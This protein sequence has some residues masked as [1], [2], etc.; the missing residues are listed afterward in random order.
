MATL[1]QARGIGAVGSLLILVG[2]VPN[3]GVLSI[4]GLILVLI[5]VKFIGEIV[6]DRDIYS[7][8]TIAVSLALIGAVVGILLVFSAFSSFIGSISTPSASSGLFVS[9][10]SL[11]GLVLPGLVVAWIFLLLSSVLVKKCYDSIAAHLGKDLFATTAK[12]FLVGALLT[13]VVGVGLIIIF[14]ASALQVAA[15]LSLPDEKPGK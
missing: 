1:R 3:A 15:F 7:N 8:M 10:S 14:V 5:A 9:F 6:N 13:I 4:A 11:I 12:L 2:F